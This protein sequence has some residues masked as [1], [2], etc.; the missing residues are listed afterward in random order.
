MKSIITKKTLKIF[1]DIYYKKGINK[2]HKFDLVI[3]KY[4]KL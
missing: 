1:G 4:I 2:T 3:V